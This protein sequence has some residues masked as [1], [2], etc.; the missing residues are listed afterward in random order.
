MCLKN[1]KVGILKIKTT[2]SLV[3][4]L[5]IIFH[6]KITKIKASFFVFLAKNNYLSNKFFDYNFKILFGSNFKLVNSHFFI[7]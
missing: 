2:T 1:Y 5:V 3:F 7:Y 6:I 4:I